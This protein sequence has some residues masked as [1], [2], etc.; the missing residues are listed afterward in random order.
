[1]LIFQGLPL[2]FW[3]EKNSFLVVYA[4]NFREMVGVKKKV[5]GDNQKL[6]EECF[7]C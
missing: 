1:M 4:V 3:R 2:K 7:F 5:D 6:G